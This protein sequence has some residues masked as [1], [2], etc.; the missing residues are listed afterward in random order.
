MYA[1]VAS[2]Y[3]PVVERL[4]ELLGSMDALGSFAAVAVSAPKVYVRP[5]IK[6]EGKAFNIYF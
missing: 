3:W 1:Q 5:V 6:K 4:S 2:T